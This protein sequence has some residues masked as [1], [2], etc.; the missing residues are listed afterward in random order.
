M[1]RNFKWIRHW[2]A[3]TTAALFLSLALAAC[4]NRVGG[5]ADMAN[6]SVSDFVPRNGSVIASSDKIMITFDKSM[7]AS[8][9]MIGGDLA[10]ESD[11]GTW[12][13]LTK[14]AGG[15]SSS[16][17]AANNTLTIGPLATWGSGTNRTLTVDANDLAGNP[18]PTFRLVLTV[19]RGIVYVS[20]GGDDTNE[21][22]KESPL[23]TIPAGI[24][25]TVRRG[26]YPGAVLVSEGTFSVD[27]STS[28]PIILAEGISLVGGFTADWTERDPGR[29]VSL[30]TDM[31]AT[32]G[33]SRRPNRAVEAKSGTG[34]TDATVIDGF[35]IQGGGGDYS[36]GLL[37][38]SSQ[39]PRILNNSIHGGAGS[40]RSTGIQV[41]SFPIIVSN[42]IDGGDGGALSYGILIVGG[43]PRIQDNT[44]HGGRGKMNSTGIQNM[45][46]SSPVIEANH[47]DGGDGAGLSI[48]IKN[49]GRSNTSPS[50][51]AI[52]NNMIHGGSGKQS[53][54]IFNEKNVSPLIEANS[55][56]GGNGSAYSTGIFNLGTPALQ[57]RNNTVSG[58]KGRISEGIH[59]SGASP[60]IEN[61]TI[62]GGSGANASAGITLAGLTGIGLPVPTSPVIQNNI[63]LTSGNGPRYCIR[64]VEYDSDPAV[65]ENND[66]YN[67][68]AGLYLDELTTELLSIDQVN[69]LRDTIASGNVSVDARIVNPDGGDYHLSGLSPALVRLG[70]LD[71]SAE[72]T[73]DRDGATRTLPWSMGAYER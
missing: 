61:N 72:F 25:K 29:H 43:S 12:S 53:Y 40:T 11:R 1:S 20:P 64:E 7:D 27:S 45:S 44:I 9:V 48:G 33:N 18:L 60:I 70:G 63:V 36:S 19:A 30:I 13:T 58:G 59:M 49:L 31:S 22:T 51:T 15:T 50:T 26:F 23:A 35:T 37:I 46:R 24:A 67:C 42:T 54:G 47:V 65:L 4:G 10:A 21:G 32:G 62:D 28:A 38:D 3:S 8:S 6:P 66:L 69:K 56:D 41:D 73:T 68:P 5:A 57:I 52:R 14:P 39:S 16:L 71:L 34:I 17:S 55:I 2:T